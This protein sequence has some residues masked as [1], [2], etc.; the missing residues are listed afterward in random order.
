MG[1]DYEHEAVHA[2]PHFR[3][4]GE[5][6]GTRM[7]RTTT[8]AVDPT[9]GAG[10]AYLAGAGK[11]EEEEV[12]RSSS[13]TRSRRS[14]PRHNQPDGYCV[15]VGDVCMS[16][17]VEALTMTLPMNILTSAPFSTPFSPMFKH[18]Y[19][20]TFSYVGVNLM[21]AKKSCAILV[22]ASLF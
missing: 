8:G 12:A 17:G 9:P 6:D 13:E 3:M 19:C 18:I 2:F 16:G 5:G 1:F 11:G 20:N 15:E 10:W 21:H 7:R 22:L 14:P 4:G